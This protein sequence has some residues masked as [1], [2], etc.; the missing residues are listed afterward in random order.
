LYELWHVASKYAVTLPRWIEG[1]FDQL[2]A[3]AIEARID[4]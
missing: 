2:D 1:K 3:P 4:E